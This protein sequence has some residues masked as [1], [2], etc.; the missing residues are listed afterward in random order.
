[1]LGLPKQ[2]RPIVL[3]TILDNMADLE[4]YTANGALCGSTKA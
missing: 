3:L 4:R 1:M 2:N